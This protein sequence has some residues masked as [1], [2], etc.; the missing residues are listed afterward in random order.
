MTDL[1]AESA[2]FKAKWEHYVTDQAVTEIAFELVTG[3]VVEAASGITLQDVLDFTDGGTSPE[4]A[5]FIH[6]LVTHPQTLKDI[7]EH[8]S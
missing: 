4:F 3:L 7:E 5:E 2:A 1:A 8:L 6:E